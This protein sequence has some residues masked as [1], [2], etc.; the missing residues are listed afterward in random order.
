MVSQLRLDRMYAYW[1]ARDRASTDSVAIAATRWTTATGPVQHRAIRTPWAICLC[2]LALILSLNASC[3]RRC[4]RGKFCHVKASVG[5]VHIDTTKGTERAR[6]YLEEYRKGVRTN[7]DLDCEISLLRTKLKRALETQ[8]PLNSSI[9][10]DEYDLGACIFGDVLAEQTNRLEP[11]FYPAFNR[12]LA[13]LDEHWFLD[14]SQR[15]CQPFFETTPRVVFVPGAFYQEEKEIR[16]GIH[17]FLQACSAIGIEVQFVHSD[18]LGSF[19]GNVCKVIEAVE[20]ASACNEPFAI[21][22]LSRGA[23]EVQAA[24]SSLNGTESIEQLHTWISVAGIPKGSYLADKATRFPQ[25][26]ATAAFLKSKNVG[27]LDDLKEMSPT[28]LRP[29][30]DNANLPSS[31]RVICTIPIALESTIDKSQR[32]RLRELKKFGINDTVG[33]CADAIIPGSISIPFTGADH[34]GNRTDTSRIGIALIATACDLH[35]CDLQRRDLYQA[36]QYKAASR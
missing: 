30:A 31:V 22:S 8:T 32:G 18:E 12:R 11:Q 4:F 10:G 26:I 34:N 6:Y 7:P 36:E 13:A 15:E 16:E 17:S 19:D 29:R 5:P 3:A 2:I 9:Y 28:V 1:K 35:Q 33:L 25:S 27:N 20:K 24:L 23:A 14:N 21:L